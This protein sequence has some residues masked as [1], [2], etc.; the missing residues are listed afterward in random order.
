MGYTY[1]IFARTTR[2]GL[3]IAYIAQGLTLGFSAAATPGPF[4]AYLLSQTLKNG[5][6]R[7]LL[8]ALA[9]I[10]SDGPI[11]T[12]VLLILTQ[13]PDWLLTA[14]Q[15]AGALFIL[16]LARGAYLVFKD[17]DETQPSGEES[18]QQ[19]LLEATTINLLNPNPYIFWGTIGGPILVEGWRKAPPCG[20]GFI[21]GFYVTLITG[22]AGFVILFG[23]ARHLGPRVSRILSGIAAAVLLLLGIYQLV[24][25]VDGL[26]AL[27][28]A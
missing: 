1:A 5:W 23:T 13:T 15:T 21:L 18:S 10:L 17:F 8:A 14:L 22:L 3:L 7:T 25:G 16:Y 2:G 24:T 28:N 20:A 9:P 19:S 6:K 4:Q 26:R 11:I 27:L 12:L